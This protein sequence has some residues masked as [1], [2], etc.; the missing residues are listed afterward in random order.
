MIR[1][2]TPNTTMDWMLR[3]LS[4]PGMDLAVSNCGMLVPMIPTSAP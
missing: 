4:S 1:P 2:I 3:A